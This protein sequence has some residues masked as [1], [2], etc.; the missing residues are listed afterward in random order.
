[1]FDDDPMRL[2]Y[3][4]MVLI[5]PLSALAAYKLSWKRGLLYALIWG[6]IFVGL[7]LLIGAVMG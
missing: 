3:L 7:A 2:V 1:M 6:S 4:L 5:L